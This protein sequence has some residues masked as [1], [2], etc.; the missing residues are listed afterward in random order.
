M[1][2]LGIA[3]ATVQFLDVGARLLIILSR[4]CTDLRQ[5]LHNIEAAGEK[6]REFTELVRKLEAEVHAPNAGAASTLNGAL[7][8]AQ[9]DYGTSLL[10]Q[11]IDQA[12]ELEK[13]LRTLVSD[14][15][16]RALKKA[17]RAVVCVKTEKDISDKLQELKTSLSLWYNHE[18]FA[19]LKNQA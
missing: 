19:L 14:P 15:A 10:K 6:L 2:E 7:S 13:V 11:C 3:A 8:P 1:A 4:V 17:W 12:E 5:V 18:S 16:D 9:V